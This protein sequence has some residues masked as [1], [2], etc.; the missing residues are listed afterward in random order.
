MLMEHLLGARPCTGQGRW[1]AGG[2]QRTKPIRVPTLMPL[3]LE[4]GQRVRLLRKSKNRMMSRNMACRGNT[5]AVTGGWGGGR[6]PVLSRRKRM[7]QGVPGRQHS[8]DEGPLSLRMRRET[9][10]AAGDQQE[11][12]SQ[13]PAEPCQGH[14]ATRRRLRVKSQQPLSGSCE[15]GQG[16]EGRLRRPSHPHSTQEQSPAP[17]VYKAQGWFPKGSRVHP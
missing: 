14:K 9:V 7:V 16:Q 1:G 10:A 2:K 17:R 8:E 3:V 6:A 15:P 12:R 13:R 4:Q 11:L 5:A